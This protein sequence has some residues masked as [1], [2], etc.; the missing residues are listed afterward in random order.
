MLYVY[1][2]DILVAT[3]NDPQLHEEIMY[4]V[5]DLLEKESFFL[6]PSKCHFEQ[7][8]IDY[9]GIYVEKG[10]IHIDP[11]KQNGLADWPREL[12]TVRQV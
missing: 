3:P 4:Q 6:K 8:S 11:T 7:E 5:L 2:D 9:L 12:K 1:M 10:T